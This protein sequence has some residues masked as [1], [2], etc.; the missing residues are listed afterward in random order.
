MVVI[1]CKQD[2]NGGEGTGCDSD[3]DGNAVSAIAYAS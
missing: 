1:D 2:A 3:P